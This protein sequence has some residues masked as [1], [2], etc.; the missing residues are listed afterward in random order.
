MF[1]CLWMRGEEQRQDILSFGLSLAFISQSTWIKHVHTCTL[2]SVTVKHVDDHLQTVNMY[3]MSI[4]S[5]FD[6][7][8][9]V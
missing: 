7:Y 6:S 8:E 2:Q 9:A 1:V 3:E 5:S 4:L